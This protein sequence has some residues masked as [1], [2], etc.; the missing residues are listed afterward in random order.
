[1]LNSR[2]LGTAAAACFVALVMG[3]S[4][5]PKT[6]AERQSLQGEAEAAYNSM[7]SKDASLRD[8]VEKGAGYAVFPSVGKAGLIAGGA[9]GR[10]VLYENGRPTGYVDLKQG[11]V[12]AQIG[13][14]TYNEL[15]VFETQSNIDQVK[16]GE[17]DLGATASA[18]ALKAG[19]GGAS[20]FK[21][22]LAVFIQPKGGMMAEASI[23]GQKL[24]FVPMDQSETASS[25]SSSST[26]RSSSTPGNEDSGVEVKVESK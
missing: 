8:F 20:R 3:C 25:S 13:A 14:Q 23:T 18:V 11:S 24:N 5:A 4:T 2:I 16:N 15:V 12:G 9:Y 6:S 21:N 26:M 17:F 22:G 7:Q 19:V 1:M 10:G